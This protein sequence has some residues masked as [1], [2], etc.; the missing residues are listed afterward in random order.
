MA[1]KIIRI[2]AM[3]A[4]CLAIVPSLAFAQDEIDCGDPGNSQRTECAGIEEIVVTGSFI[5]RGKFEMASPVESISPEV[6][7]QAGHTTIGG[8]IRNLPYTQ[9]VDTVANTL[10]VQDGQQDSNSAQ[11]NLRGLGSSS[12][13]TLLDGRRAIDP[14]STVSIL[15][16]LAIGSIDIVLD[17]GAAT[18]GTD[19]IAGVVNFI[20]LQSYEGFKVRGFYSVDDGWDVPEHKIS[21]L[22]GH[23]WDK[24][25]IVAA[26]D[27]SERK[28]PLFRSDRSRYLR[29]DSD[30]SPS[31]NPGTY[32]GLMGLQRDPACGTYNEGHLDDGKAGSYPSGF[33]TNVSV[34]PVCTYEYGEFQDYKRPNDNF[35]FYTAATYD[36]NDDVVLKAMVNYSDRTSWLT[37]SPTTAVASNNSLL[38]IPANHPNNP[39]GTAVRPYSSFWRPFTSTGDRTEPSHFQN[40]AYMPEFSFETYQVSLGT[41]FN[42]GATG[43]YGEF[44][45]VTGNRTAH[46]DGNALSMDRLQQ[47]LRGEGGVN[48]DQWFNPFGSAS[49]HAP[50]VAGSPNTGFGNCE[51]GIGATDP[52]T[53][54]ACSNND[55]ALV[56]WLF[57]PGNQDYSEEDYWSIEGFVG[58]EIFELPAGMVGFAVGAQLRYRDELNRPLAHLSTQPSVEFPNAGPN[59]TPAGQDYNTSHTNGLGVET[60]GENK[61]RSL[62]TEFDVPL[63]DNLSMTAALRYEDFTDFNMSTTVPKISFRW[64]PLDNLALRASWGEGFLAPTIREALVRPDPSCSELLTAATDGFGIDRTGALSCYNG[65]ANLDPESSTVTNVG[66]TWNATDELDISLDYQQ[67]K[68]EDRIVALSANDVVDRDH[69]AFLQTTPN[70]ASLSSA[71]QAAARAAWYVSG[72][73]PAITRDPT[74]ERITEIQTYSDNINAMEVDV[75]DFR[76]NYSRS[77]DKWGFFSANLSTTYYPSYKYRDNTTGR[78]VEAIGKQNGDTNLA[79]PLPKYKNVLRMAWLLDRHN[80]AMTIHNQGSVEFDATVGPTYGPSPVQPGQIPSR[81]SAYTT[82]DIRYGHTFY[83]VAGGA[84]DLG[85][86]SNNVTNNLAQRLPVPAGLET[87]LQ[88]PIGRTLYIEGT[89]SF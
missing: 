10:G 55:Q 3:I 14:T 62:F 67:I 6:M 40:G 12:T 29:A 35:V 85:I 39:Y 2:S 41:E 26:M 76:V 24:L 32:V 44:W 36:L 27:Y 46:V 73:D 83:D 19:A 34:I 13:L 30:T 80:V 1:V 71:A 43:W 11:F 56:D 50:P 21:M 15:P 84:L 4:G 64:V 45:A 49:P 65:N 60:Y 48:G 33:P 51:P 57:V 8:L 31:G 37:S 54:L 68:Y 47:A 61:V 77:W 63:L 88:D 22:W 81:I 79:P 70:Y 59:G 78:Y 38:S 25:N 17:G 20:P 82:V 18:Y 5:R 75:V 69:A 23:A 42:I 58:G 74:T 89:Y 16:E 53:G 7:L 72:Q 86:G 66:F 87:R 52:N 28:D 9:N